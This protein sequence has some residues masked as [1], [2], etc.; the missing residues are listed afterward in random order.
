MNKLKCGTI[1]LSTLL[2]LST[3]A[4]AYS[5]NLISDKRE[6]SAGDKIVLSVK[7]QDLE[8]EIDTYQAK[9]VYDSSEF[10]S[11]TER[12]FALK[13]EWTGLAFNQ[14][15]G[16]FVVEKE[17]KTIQD[18]DV[19]T[20]TLESKSKLDANNLSIALINNVVSG[21]TSDMKTADVSV[22]ID[23]IEG[24]YIIDGSYIRDVKPKTPVTDF[25]SI[26]IDGRDISV[27]V[28]ENNTEV[29]QGE[30]KTGMKVK[31]T[32][33]N[34][35]T[36]YTICVIGDVNGDGLANSIDSRMIKAYRNEIVSLEEANAKAAD[37]NN[38][39]KVNINDTKLLLY[40]RADVSG[41]NFNYS[42]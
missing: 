31:V 36:E 2:V 12:N 23:I 26:F 15:N 20:I 7:L 30:V 25:K 10:G 4:R 18:E 21:G 32:E 24:G 19:L 3:E 33:N 38:D 39:G 8:S 28:L 42:K 13:N 40:H 1:F 37:I 27:K 5:L 9:L 11:V 14:E 22:D 17:N 16:I 41:Y 34:K 29:T 6:I 35:V